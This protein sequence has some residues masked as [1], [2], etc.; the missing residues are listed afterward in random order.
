MLAVNETRKTQGR[1]GSG[2]PKGA[3]TTERGA[4][5]LL[6]NKGISAVEV[7]VVF[8]PLHKNTTEQCTEFIAMLLLNSVRKSNLQFQTNEVIGISFR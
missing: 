4:D 1:V 5:R 3:P 8:R 2:V 6:L 7:S